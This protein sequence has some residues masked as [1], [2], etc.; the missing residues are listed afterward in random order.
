V[1]RN[2]VYDLWEAAGSPPSGQRPGEGELVAE[3]PSG[4]VVRCAVSPAVI[5]MTGDIDAMAM[6]AGLGVGAVRSIEPAAEI[7]ER[8]ARV[9][10]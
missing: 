4:P 5:G 9:L 1:L 2:E 7:V 6:S 10:A 3:G 8:F